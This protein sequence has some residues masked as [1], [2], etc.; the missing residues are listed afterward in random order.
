MDTRA[1]FHCNT[2]FYEDLQRAE[3]GIHGYNCV[4]QC[5]FS[6]QIC[7][8]T[9]TLPMQG[10]FSYNSKGVKILSCGCQIYNRNNLY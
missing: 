9:L 7:K 8:K 5:G 10:T 4:D 2:S 1:D 6:L 3:L